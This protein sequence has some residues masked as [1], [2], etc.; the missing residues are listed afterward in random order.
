MTNSYLPVRGDLVES[1][2]LHIPKASDLVQ[3]LLSSRLAF[4][5]LVECRREDSPSSTEVV[6]LDVVVER[7]QRT[8]YD[9]HHIERV[10]V[11]FFAHDRWAPE[12][13]ALRE[14][15]PFVPH[16]NLRPQ[17]QELPRSLCLYDEPYE[18]IKLRWMPPGSSS[19]SAPGWPRRQKGSYIRQ[20]SHLSRCL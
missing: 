12:V 18:D 8:V 14:D 6:V 20:I 19:G 11:R 3:T 2:E 7:G 13:L 9:I 15:F 10:A 4:V 5:S 17:G 1:A 16:L